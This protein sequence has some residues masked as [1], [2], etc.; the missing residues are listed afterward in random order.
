MSCVESNPF[1]LNRRSFLTT[2]AGGVGLLALEYLAQSE[3]P[4]TASAGAGVNPLAARQPHHPPRA[5]SVILLFQ[6]GGPSQMD[7]F[8]RKPELLKHHG[9]PYPGEIE[10]HF[11]TQVRNLL[12][13]PFTFSRYGQCGMELSE[14]LP[15][16]G[17]IADDITLVRSMMTKSIDHEQALRLIHSGSPF[18][19]K[20]TWGSWVVYGLGSECE[21]LPAF[22]V[23]TDH[24]GL[25]V[26][27]TKNWTSG[28]LP[29]VCQGTQ[30]RSTGSP[31]LNLT[32]P[33]NTTADARGNQLL[34]LKQLN[35]AH[36]GR[37]SKNSELQARISNYELAARMQTSVPQALDISSETKHTRDLYG[38]DN[39]PT[40]D[41]GMRCLMARRLIEQ[42]VRF[43]SIY[44]DG[45]PWD[46]H[47]NNAETV[48]GL[49][50]RTDQPSAALV[51]DLKQ[52]GLLDSTIVMWAGEFGR[53][54]VSQGPDGRDHNRRAFSLWLAGGGFKGGYVHGATDDFGYRSVDDVVVVHDL[55]ATLLHALGLDHRQ[56]TYPHEGRDDTLT[57]VAVT[58]ADMV[59]A[60]LK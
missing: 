17:S 7:L 26:D 51:K 18:V 14:T 46:T 1:S 38:L 56:L 48:E 33:S 45:Q 20:A 32:T 6:N 19:G 44:L 58:S 43:V 13:S 28:F 29:A 11:H 2:T 57:D 36:R 49:A 34:L 15:H 39:T 59:P 50:A 42:G 8:D 52:R 47:S 54:P 53:L 23:L 21:E 22:V 25:P 55:H 41:Y 27:G 12:G 16:T 35:E 10:A 40:A 4:A 3:A 60:L 31:V 37:H 30:F 5:K 9:K 24:A